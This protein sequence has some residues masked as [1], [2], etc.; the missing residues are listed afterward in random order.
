MPNTALLVDDLVPQIGSHLPSD[1]SVPKENADPLV[2][3]LL[4]ERT[5]SS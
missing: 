2:I 5:Y 1:I 4:F 3:Y